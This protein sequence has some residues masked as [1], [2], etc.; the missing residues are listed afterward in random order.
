[1]HNI[2]TTR[3]I[4]ATLMSCLRA[5]RPLYVK[6]DIEGVPAINAVRSLTAIIFDHFVFSFAARSDRCELP[7]NYPLNPFRFE[8]AKNCGQRSTGSADARSVWPLLLL[9][10]NAWHLT[11]V[12]TGALIMVFPGSGRSPVR[13]RGTAG[14]TS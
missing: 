6:S 13:I 8:N 7:H 12:R 10:Y 1:M 3:R 11:I 2:L 9:G 14:R 4:C 5:A